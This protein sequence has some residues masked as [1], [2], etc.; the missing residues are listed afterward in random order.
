MADTLLFYDT[1]TS[2]MPLWSKPSSDKDQPHILQVAALLVDASSRKTIASIDLTVRPDGWSINPE[3]LAVHGITEEHARR[4]GVSETTALAALHDLWQRASTRVGHVESFDARIVRIA[5][6]RHGWGTSLADAWKAGSAECTAEL[7]KPHVSPKGR[8]RGPKLADAYR[9]YFGTDL[10][11]AH[12]ARADA[13]A[14]AAVY[15]AVRD[16]HPS[17][18]ERK[19]R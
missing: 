14:C 1:E 17:T 11:D 9:H 16:R 13:E 2:D 8:A 12:S 7:S 19:T 15:W 3:A 18:K 5:L 4:V 10:P 6:I